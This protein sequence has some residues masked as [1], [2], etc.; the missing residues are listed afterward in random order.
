M[1]KNLL[2]HKT[3]RPQQDIN[4]RSISNISTESLETTICHKKAEFIIK[5]CMF[6]EIRQVKDF[7]QYCI[8][9]DLMKYMRN[10]F[11]KCKLQLDSLSIMEFKMIEKYIIPTLRNRNRKGRELESPLVLLGVLEMRS[12]ED[13]LNKLRELEEEGRDIEIYQLI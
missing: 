11:L 8:S 5:V 9:I 10:C 2:I 6:D 7:S 12:K 4:R 1:E 13:L 3:N